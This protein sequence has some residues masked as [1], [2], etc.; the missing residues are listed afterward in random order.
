MLALCPKINDATVIFKKLLQK[1]PE[2][3]HLDCNIE[4]VSFKKPIDSSNI[5]PEK[6]VEIAEIIENNYT[7]FDGFVKYGTPIRGG[8]SS[9]FDF[10]GLSQR[11]SASGEITPNRI[12]QP[13]FS[14]IRTET[15][16]TIAD[17]ATIVL[18]G[19]VEES[20]QNVE[21]KVPILGSMP[22]VGRLFQSKARQPIRRNVLIMVNVELQDPAG[23]P[24]RNR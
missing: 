20:V 1:I 9:S 13:V 16:L 14:I 10:G 12:L 5:D 23:K 17:G 2:L 8:A 11:S 4:T 21:D 24:Y 6:W 7:N 19:M 3:K 15:S 18:G 22:F